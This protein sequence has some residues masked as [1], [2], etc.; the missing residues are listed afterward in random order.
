LL[1]GAGGAGHV[2]QVE[3]HGVE[4]D[5]EG[6][7]AGSELAR[8]GGVNLLHDAVEVCG[9]FGGFAVGVGLLGVV[10]AEDGNAPEH[11]V[12]CKFSV[13]HRN[14]LRNTA[15]QIRQVLVF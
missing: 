3:P 2:A 11:V 4:E 13:V 8:F 12:A 7:G 6:G 5:S 14:F 1:D 15:A 10:F 9:V